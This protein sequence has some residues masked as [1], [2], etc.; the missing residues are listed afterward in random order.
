MKGKFTGFAKKD[1]SR[2]IGSKRQRTDDTSMEVETRPFQATSKE[3]EEKKI[4][5]DN[6]EVR[7]KEI[8]AKVDEYCA[9]NNISHEKFGSD[10]VDQLTKIR[11]AHIDKGDY[12]LGC[13]GGGHLIKD[14]SWSKSL[15]E[16]AQTMGEDG[17]ALYIQYLIT[18]WFNNMFRKSYEN[19]VKRAS[20]N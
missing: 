17:L 16:K 11:Q 18:Q 12:C 3:V 1:N 8:S 5:F 19:S 20:N 14:C 4:K 13:G 7:F 2:S 15:I 6:S 9:K 10:R